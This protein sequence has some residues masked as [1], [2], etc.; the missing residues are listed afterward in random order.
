V[1]YR[2][3][4]HFAAAKGGLFV[5]VLLPVR[6]GSSRLFIPWPEIAAAI[7]KSWMFDYVV[8]TFSKAPRVRMRLRRHDAEAIAAA[9]DQTLEIGAKER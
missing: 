1:N 5:W 3:A 8:L 6:L 7:E 9:S 2:N 4:L